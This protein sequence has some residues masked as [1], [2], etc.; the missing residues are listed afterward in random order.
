MEIGTTYVYR[1]KA[2][3]EVLNTSE[4][5]EAISVNTT[6]EKPEFSPNEGRYNK[7]QTVALSN[8]ISG[9]TIYYTIDGSNPATGSAIYTYPI[10]VTETTMIKA[11]AVKEGMTASDV[12]NA[13][14]NTGRHSHWH[15]WKCS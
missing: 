9:A 6:L 2:I 15:G 7:E 11:I 4:L 13:E 3:N 8:N 14:Y 1:I 12:A 10:N 5:S